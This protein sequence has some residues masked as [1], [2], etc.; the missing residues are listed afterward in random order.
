MKNDNIIK[1]THEYLVIISAKWLKKHKE[2]IAVPN[3]Q[4]IALENMTATGETP[5]VIGWCSWASV[6]MEI[7]TSRQDFKKDLKKPFRESPSLG[8]GD[9]RLYSCPKGLIKPDEIPRNWGLLYYS[10][11]KLEMVITPKKIKSNLESER[12][13]LVSLIRKLTK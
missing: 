12:T 2:N 9:F 1:I 7:K 3:C 13:M 11:K 6:I 8:A 4:T 5:D 10:G